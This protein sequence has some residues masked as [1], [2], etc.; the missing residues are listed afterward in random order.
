MCIGNSIAYLAFMLSAAGLWDEWLNVILEK[1][2]S[3]REIQLY[4]TFLEKLVNFEEAQ[5]LKEIF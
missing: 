1:N 5:I 2:A 3:V 4:S